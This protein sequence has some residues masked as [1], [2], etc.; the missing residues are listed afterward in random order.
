MWSWPELAPGHR[1]FRAAEGNDPL[2]WSPGA[3][4]GAGEVS[5]ALA[6]VGAEE[7]E[8]QWAARVQ[9][10]RE[11]GFTAG[12]RAGRENASRAASARMDAALDALAAATSVCLEEREHWNR[13]LTENLSALALAAARH[14]VEHQ[15]RED[16]A[17]VTHLVRRALTS[18]PPDQR[19]RIRL[20]PEDLS[21]IT[22]RGP[23]GQAMVPR[24]REVEWV[25][26]AA[27]LR[28]GCMVEGPESVVDG[29]VD[30][31]LERIYWRLVE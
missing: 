18:F 19:I 15:V 5:P 31:A 8:R 10:A 12:E 16:P 23:E 11:E 20:N 27:I 30:T 26:D 3:L 28:G 1:S 21:A 24:G 6:P 7:L 13:T 2:P 17:V 22:A 14:L 29:R 4:G 9:E 25:A